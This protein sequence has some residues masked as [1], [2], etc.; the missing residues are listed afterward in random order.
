MLHWQHSLS[1]NLTFF[2]SRYRFRTRQLLLCRETAYSIAH[3][4]YPQVAYSSHFHLCDSRQTHQL[5]RRAESCPCSYTWSRGQQLRSK[6]RQHLRK[7]RRRGGRLPPPK[8]L[9]YSLCMLGCPGSSLFHKR[10]WLDQ[11][12]RRILRL[13]LFTDRFD[14][15]CH[16]Y[17]R[18]APILVRA[19]AQP[20]ASS[21]SQILSLTWNL[22]K[23]RPK[24]PCRHR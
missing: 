17:Q 16:L 13:S 7:G 24:Y 3:H 2:I 23:Q 22:G 12:W 10:I 20:L 6:G 8:S 4:P 5:I 1:Y 21:W 14:H 18:L 15:C 19:S 9:P 11:W